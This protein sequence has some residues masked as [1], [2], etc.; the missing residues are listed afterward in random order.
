M[1]LRSPKDGWIRVKWDHGLKEKYRIGAGGD[2]D[3]VVDKEKVVNSKTYGLGLR[4]R[5]GPDW[6]WSYYDQDN[7]GL[8]TTVEMKLVMRAGVL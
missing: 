4:V 3:L 8:G 1:L 7:N 5:R 6:H 2:Y